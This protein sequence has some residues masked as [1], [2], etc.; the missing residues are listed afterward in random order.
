MILPARKLDGTISVP[1]DKSISHRAVMLASI[2]DSVIKITNFAPG[3][4]CVSTIRCMRQLGVQIEH[5]G[6]TVTVHGVG[7]HGLK[8]PDAPLDCGNSGTTMRLL[9]GLLAG[10]PFEAVLTGDKSLSGRPMARIIEP[11]TKMGAEI[12]SNDGLPPLTVRGG[13][14]KGIEFTSP[15]PSAQAK[16]AVLLAGLFADGPTRVVESVPTRD[17]TERMLKAIEDGVFTRGEVSIPGDISSAVFFIAAAACLSGS[18][19]RLT[20]VG[21]NPTR[22]AILDVLRRL[23]A[24]IEIVTPEADGSFEPEADIIVRG[25]LR[26]ADITVLDGDVIPKIIDEIPVLAVLGT[27]LEGGLEVKD[28]GELRIKES[29]RITGIVNNLKKMGSSV[30]EFEDG[31]RVECSRLKGAV[32]DS[33]GDHRIAMAFAVAGLFAEGVTEILDPECVNVSYPGFFEQLKEVAVR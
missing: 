18:D 31:F 3:E 5:E 16:S 26:S 29:D 20:N 30:T 6:S 28:A 10:Q 21:V 7:K 27:Q 32:I 8:K 9:A 33:Y 23:G 2:A 4:D 15:I 24:S 13:R 11:L 19:L 22:T 14:L 17:H 12:R 25:G 1:G